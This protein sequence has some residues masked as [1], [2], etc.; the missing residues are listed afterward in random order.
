MP[1]TTR[2]CRLQT[3]GGSPRPLG[4]TRLRR[5]AGHQGSSPPA[6]LVSMSLISAPTV[7]AR[8][9]GA[10]VSGGHPERL[11]KRGSAATG[12]RQPRRSDH[13][14]RPALPP[15]RRRLLRRAHGPPCGPHP[16][17]DRRPGPRQLRPGRR[18]PEP[19]RGPGQPGRGPG[20]SAAHRVQRLGGRRWHHEDA[21]RS[22][23]ATRTA[24]VSARYSRRP[25]R[26][27]FAGRPRSGS[28]H[29]AG[30]PYPRILSSADPAVLSPHRSRCP[31]QM[32]LRPLPD[33][34]EFR[35]AWQPI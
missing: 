14:A 3:A 6:N 24:T 16:P 31:R 4:G 26:L 1:R 10:V 22:E 28:K 29:P 13:W 32:R 5:P 21:C 35:T 8:R 34:C 30:V 12:P 33:P 15:S 20:R 23:P 9:V 17:P 7:P 11:A 19:P 18:S 27:A 2:D 25:T